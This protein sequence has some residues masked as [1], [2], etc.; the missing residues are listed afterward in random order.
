[1]REQAMVAERDAQPMI[2]IK[3]GKP[4]GKSLPSRLIEDF[5]SC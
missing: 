2:E 4:D 5:Q 1:M 3:D